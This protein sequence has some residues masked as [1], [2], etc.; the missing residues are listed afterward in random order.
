MLFL[1]RFLG[2]RRMVALYLLRTAWR[3]Y[4]GRVRRRLST[5]R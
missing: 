5:G 3:I 1:F 2:V 4:R